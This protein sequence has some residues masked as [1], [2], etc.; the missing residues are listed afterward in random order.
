LRSK[1]KNNIYCIKYY[2]THYS[3]NHKNWFPQEKIQ[4]IILIGHYVP[5]DFFILMNPKYS[6]L[7][8]TLA[9]KLGSVKNGLDGLKRQKPAKGF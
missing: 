6:K 8:G 4:K 5:A 2:A 3:G 9:L 7:K 1:N